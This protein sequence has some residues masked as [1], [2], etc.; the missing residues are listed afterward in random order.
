V[1]VTI[2]RANNDL[3]PALSRAKQ[4]GNRALITKYVPGREVSCGVLVTSKTDLIPLPPTELIPGADYDFFDYDAKYTPGATKEVTP[5]DMPETTIQEIKNMAKKVHQLIGA[6]GYSRTDM[7]VGDDGMVY[8]L[9]IN[10][11]PG[12]TPTSILPQQAKA[13][14]LSFGQLLS[15]ICDNVDNSASEYV[16]ATTL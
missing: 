10:T 2:V 14:G 5:P 6:D 16:T 8:V 4:G 9:E 12:L 3:S 11:L 13:Y 1:N 7:I 15:T